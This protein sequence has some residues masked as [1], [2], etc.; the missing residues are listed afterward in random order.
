SPKNREDLGVQQ[1]RAAVIRQVL[2]RAAAGLRR[3]ECVVLVRKQLRVF[4]VHVVDALGG[5]ECGDGEKSDNGEYRSPHPVLLCRFDFRK[6][7][8]TAGRQECTPPKS[9]GKSFLAALSSGA[10]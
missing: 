1:Y 5:C 2:V 7:P 6:C 3:A 10:T 8:S 9:E 4:A